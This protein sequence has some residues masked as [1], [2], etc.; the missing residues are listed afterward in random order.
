MTRRKKIELNTPASDQLQRI[1][2][3]VI[4]GAVRDIGSSN[5][6]NARDVREWIRKPS[7][8]VCCGIANWD[9]SWVLDL[10]RSIDNL[11]EPVKRPITKQCLIMLQAVIRITEDSGTEDT[12]VVTHGVGN[13]EH[14]M[15]F[16]GHAPN[17]MSKLSR[18][19][20]E[21]TRRRNGNTIGGDT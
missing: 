21:R 10:L 14:D 16:I 18:A 12:T 3:D 7:F 5:W 4:Y 13:T 15:K 1:Y 19:S 8:G 6:Q 2:R 17:I 11:D 9:E 20:H